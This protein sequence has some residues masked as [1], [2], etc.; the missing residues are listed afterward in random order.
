MSTI[1][2]T[3]IKNAIY[4][5][6]SPLTSHIYRDNDWSGVH[7][8]IDTAADAVEKLDS[9]LS[10]HYDVV[11][12]GYRTSR[13]GY[14]HYKEYLLYVYQMGKVVLKGHLNAHGAGSMND[15]YERYDMTVVLY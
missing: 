4:K 1:S 10:L 8:V 3:R 6:V 7:K 2:K 13:D 9:G 14:S 11:D 15:P 5:A 12:G